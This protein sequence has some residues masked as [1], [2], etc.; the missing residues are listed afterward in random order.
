MYSIV[1]DFV[2]LSRHM[3]AHADL[4]KLHDL[5]CHVSPGIETSSK[6]DKESP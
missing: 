4:L 2:N 3:A 6:A 5:F 1:I